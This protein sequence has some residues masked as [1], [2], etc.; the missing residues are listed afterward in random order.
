MRNIGCSTEK[1]CSEKSV[2]MRE[3]EKGRKLGS[4]GG[5][6]L[7]WGGRGACGSV[8]KQS[9]RAS[10]RDKKPFAAAPS[11]VGRYNVQRTAPQEAALARRCPF[12]VVTSYVLI[13]S[14][15]IRVPREKERER[16]RERAAYTQPA[17]PSPAQPG[18]RASGASA[19]K[20]GA[21]QVFEA[22]SL[23]TTKTSVSGGL[24][25]A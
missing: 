1:L 6:R 8:D 11:R 22:S 25:R 19:R 2:Y 13:N 3:Q 18:R 15:A 5:E 24:A 12:N 9:L 14:A 23:K 4:Q 10:T 16:E 7:V 20:S 17:Q 21:I